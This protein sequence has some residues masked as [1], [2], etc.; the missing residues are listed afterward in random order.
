MY[1]SILKQYKVSSPEELFNKELRLPLYQIKILIKYNH[2]SSPLKYYTSKNV[3]EF[4]HI[5]LDTDIYSIL[6]LINCDDDQVEDYLISLLGDYP[7]YTMDIISILWGMNINKAKNLL[8]LLVNNNFDNVIF[9]PILKLSVKNARNEYFLKKY[10]K[11]D[12]TKF[13]TIFEYFKDVIINENL[14]DY[15]SQFFE[16]ISNAKH[17]K[18]WEQ[19]DGTDTN[20]IINHLKYLNESEIKEVFDWI[21]LI[22]FE[23]E[24]EDYVDFEQRPSM[25]MFREGKRQGRKEIIWKNLRYNVGMITDK[26]G[27]TYWHGGD[28][29]HWFGVYIYI[30]EKFN[31]DFIKNEI[32]LITKNISFWESDKISQIIMLNNTKLYIDELS[33]MFMYT[34]NKY[35]IKNNK[36]LTNY[37]LQLKDQSNNSQ[38]MSETK[39][40]LASHGDKEL[41]NFIKNM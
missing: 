27:E 14:N 2:N 20:Y 6:N 36:I 40:I 1:H 4:V 10:A 24:F 11:L 13:K 37:I 25:L 34:N 26:W 35:I 8:K 38:I 21:K 15:N 30:L 9:D 29:P 19:D 12:A 28:Y 33:K 32:I 3:N 39:M 7:K 5:L 16:W 23:N 17:N 31:F 18:I 22:T 41:K